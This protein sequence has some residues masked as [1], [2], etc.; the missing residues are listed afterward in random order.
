MRISL[1]ERL[2]HFRVVI[3]IFWRW[4]LHP[5]F[6]YKFARICKVLRGTITCP[7]INRHDGTRWHI[8][9]AYHVSFRC[10]S[11][12]QS[13]GYRRVGTQS[14][15]EACRQVFNLL[16]TANSHV[17]FHD[18]SRADKFC[19]P[20][21]NFRGAQEVVCASREEACSF[22]QLDNGYYQRGRQLILVSLPAM[23]RSDALLS[24]S[25]TVILG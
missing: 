13:H 5:T 22:E 10:R 17:G 11:A 9:V 19:E 25:G 23:M 18:K 21:E 1:P 12:L 7:L 20:L 14:F 24:I 3:C 4:L 6:W 16:K 15:F 8:L 2:Q